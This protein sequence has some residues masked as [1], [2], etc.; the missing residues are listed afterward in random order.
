MTEIIALTP[1]AQ[2]HAKALLSNEE[3]PKGGLRI[4]V[5]GGGCSGLQYKLGWDDATEDDMTHHYENGLT[6]IVDDKSAL[7]L[8]GSTLEY[9][10]DI[11]RNGF[12][13]ENPNA[14]SCCGCGNSFN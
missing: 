7:H 4:A 9:Y 12:E 3:E 2:E 13:V 1:K 14:K 6:V 5:I 8:T 11:N 10:D